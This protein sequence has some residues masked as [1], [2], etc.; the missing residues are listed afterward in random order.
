[1]QRNVLSVGLLVVLLIT[2][3]CM[4]VGSNDE[5]SPAADTTPTPT[6][7]ADDSTTG[8]DT[9]DDPT[10]T[11]DS[12]GSDEP[13]A[14]ATSR[15]SE[16]DGTPSG[17]DNWG[18]TDSEAALRAASSFTSSWTW[19]LSN[20]ETGG[21]DSVS[22][23][24]AVDLANERA[25]HTMTISGG[26]GIIMETFHTDGA[27]Y[28]RMASS[29]GSDEPFYMVSEQAFDAD[30]VLDYRGFIYDTTALDDWAFEG[31]ERYDGVSVRRYSYQGSDPWL[32]TT[33]V[34]SEFTAKSWTFTMLVDRDGIVRYQTYRVDGVDGE[35][36]AM[37]VEWEY[38]VTGVDSTTVADPGW[39]NDAKAHT[40]ERS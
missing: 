33:H 18:A 39:L 3:G 25:H 38:T 2:A 15:D 35:N 19:Q 29:D 6:S 5:G 23:S 26:D 32:G 8:S 40:S 24:S 37:W 28:T 21:V 11:A 12:A 7:V 13:T 27:I 22:A 17:A 9:G 4:G 14:T 34:D 31:T 20:P 1:M 10:T 36:N 30:E 16:T